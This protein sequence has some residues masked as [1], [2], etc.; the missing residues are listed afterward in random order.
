MQYCGDTLS[1]KIMRD[2]EKEVDD[3]GLEPTLLSWC[4]PSVV[5]RDQEKEVEDSGLEPLPYCHCEL[6][7][8]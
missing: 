1:L 5:M 8:L 3:S 7:L 2:Q 4:T 6:P